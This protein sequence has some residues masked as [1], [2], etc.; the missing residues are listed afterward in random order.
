MAAADLRRL[1]ALVPG[2]RLIKAVHVT[3]EDA[4]GRA[5][6]C[7]PDADADALVLD[8]RTADRLG[9]TGRIHDWSVSARVVAAV[10]PVPVHLAGGAPARECRGGGRARAAHGFP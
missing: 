3:G 1:R 6:D 4:L 5:L 8:S 2:A 10:A 7:A 9:G